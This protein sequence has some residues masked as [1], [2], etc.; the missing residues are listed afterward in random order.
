MSNTIDCLFIGHNEMDFAE[1]EKSLREMGGNSG[2]YRDLN[3]N[4]IR[5]CCNFSANWALFSWKVLTKSKVKPLL[6]K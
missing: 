1:Y 3:L 6:C 5:F 4:F 2:A